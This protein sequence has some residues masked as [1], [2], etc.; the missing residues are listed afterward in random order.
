M[1]KKLIK[2]VKALIDEVE[3]TSKYSMSKIYDLY[4]QVF[5]TNEKPQSCASCLIR[6]VEELKVWLNK[7]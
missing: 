3:K 6:K 1:D 4:N 5:G 2:E 7:E